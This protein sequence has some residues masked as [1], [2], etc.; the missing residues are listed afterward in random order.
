MSLATWSATDRQNRVLM[1]RVIPVGR[2]SLSGIWVPSSKM[3]PRARNS[4]MHFSAVSPASL[5][6]LAEGE[7]LLDLVD[8]HHHRV[9]PGPGQRGQLGGDLVLRGHAEL[10]VVADPLGPLLPLAVQ[11]A[12]H[13]GARGQ[14]VVVVAAA[15]LGADRCDRGEVPSA[16]QL[17]PADLQRG[18]RAR[19][20]APA[21][22]ARTTCPIRAGR[23]TASSG[24][25]ARP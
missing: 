17:V 7:Q 2:L 13:V 21:A 18:R 11:P 15:V 14:G 23:R 10:G 25:S 24:T 4:L 9:Q 12:E 22:A 19:R 3:M 6:V 8:E 16:L 1:L 20:P 5:P